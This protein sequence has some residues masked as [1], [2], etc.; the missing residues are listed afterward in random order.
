MAE[1]RELSNYEKYTRRELPK[2][3]RTALETIIDNETQPIEERLKAQ[4]M[5]LIEDCQERV[6]SSYGA[7]DPT[8]SDA[9]S[10]LT[11]AGPTTGTHIS[12][13]NSSNRAADV[14]PFQSKDLADLGSSP[15]G[16]LPKLDIPHSLQPSKVEAP[17]VTDS[18]D[19]D[20]LTGGSSSS[21]ADSSISCISHANGSVAHDSD[22]LVS[23][24]AEILS[25][26]WASEAKLN[27]LEK[28][29]WENA[30]NS[31]WTF[32]DVTGEAF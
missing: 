23:Q 11:K 27:D 1:H 2:I 31:W 32:E 29:D 13:S 6:L 24:E 10:S 30:G 9:Q 22:G 7:Q 16:P 4:L 14:L 28:L 17:E 19:L 18:P 25:H 15:F 3:F 12:G 21:K 26:E 5:S 8:A 20:L